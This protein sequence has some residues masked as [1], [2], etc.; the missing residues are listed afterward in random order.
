M[1]YIA[2]SSA[3]RSG[4]AK[5]ERKTVNTSKIIPLE[6]PHQQDVMHRL[7]RVEGQIRGVLGMMEKEEPCDAIAQQLAAARKALD[8]SLIHI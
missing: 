7:R 5:K 1:G 6:R 8:L 2:K 3:A 4:V